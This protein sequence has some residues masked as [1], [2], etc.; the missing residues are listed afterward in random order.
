MAQVLSPAKS[1][2]SFKD[3]R[4]KPNAQLQGTITNAQ[5]S[6]SSFLYSSGHSETVVWAESMESSSFIAMHGDKVQQMVVAA[7]ESAFYFIVDAVSLRRF[8]FGD[9]DSISCPYIVAASFGSGDELAVRTD[10]YCMHFRRD[11]TWTNIWLAAGT[12][13]R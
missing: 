10:E 9:L 6:I 12:I 3:G 8:E 1:W 4:R 7:T 13:D 5:M 2:Q 11:K